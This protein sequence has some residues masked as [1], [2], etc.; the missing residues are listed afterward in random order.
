MHLINM[1]LESTG[2]K[3]TLRNNTNQLAIRTRRTSSGPPTSC[4]EVKL[5]TKTLLRYSIHQLIHETHSIT[6][7]RYP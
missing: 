7:L 5:L 2:S 4:S 3:Q 6:E 1:N